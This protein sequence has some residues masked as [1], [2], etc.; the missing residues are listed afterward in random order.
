MKYLF[1]LQLKNVSWFREDIISQTYYLL[2]VENADMVSKVFEKLQ[3]IHINDARISHVSHS[4]IE[5]IKKE[6]R[7][8]AIVAA[9]EKADYL[10]AA[11]GQKTG[12][13]LYVRENADARPYRQYEL[14]NVS[15]S[16]NLSS[17]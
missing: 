13:A 16:I 11:I 4:E 14:A 3:T 9:K 15:Y 6:V 2:K 12:K 17:T 8:E 1:I 7:V 10:L 5:K